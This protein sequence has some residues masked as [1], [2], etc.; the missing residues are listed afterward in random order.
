MDLQLFL[1]VIMMS[2]LLTP[3][4][5]IIT[6]ESALQQL[7]ENALTDNPHNLDELKGKFPTENLSP[8]TCVPV[9]YT[10]RCGSQCYNDS[11]TVSDFNCTSP[12][13]YTASFLW[14]VFSTTKFPGNMLIFWLIG[15]VRVLG[16]DWD[17]SCKFHL[18][19]DSTVMLLLP[20]ITFPC[21]SDPEGAT[22]KAL[23]SITLRVSE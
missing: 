16:F 4:F 11:D 13:G 21:I 6:N 15:G 9:Q 17:D 22:E 12:S 1:P 14:T 3:G 20:D 8:V 2:V 10:I 23:E 5:S 18:N 7:L 19:T